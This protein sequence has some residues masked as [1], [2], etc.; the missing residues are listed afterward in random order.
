MANRDLRLIESVK[1]YIKVMVPKFLEETKIREDR[2]LQHPLDNDIVKMLEVFELREEDDDYRIFYYVKEIKEIWR[3]IIEKSIK[4]LRFFDG[5]EPFLDNVSKNPIA[6]GVNELSEYF[7]QYTQFETMLYGGGKYYRD[8]VVHVFRVW[9]LGLDCLLD[10]EGEYLKRINIQE[11][12]TVNSFEKICI[13]SM[14][15]LTH[16]LGYPLEKAQ[17]II[18]KT[19]T[20]MKSFVSNPTVLL[21]LSFDGIQN[22]MNDFVVRFMSSKMHQVEGK[23]PLEK[24]SDSVEKPFVARLQPKYYFK[25][26]K[27]LERYNHGILSAIIVYKLLIYFLESD[28]NINEDYR[29]DK[30]EARQFY[31]RREILRA[32][33]AHTCHDVYHLDML[34]F[35]FLL[36]MADDAQE[37][38]RKRISELYVKQ[39]SNY[40][41]DSI[42]PF[43]DVKKSTKG[44]DGDKQINI[45][46][47]IVKEQFKFPKGEEDN[48]KDILASLMRQREGY[49]ELFRDGQDT[50]KRN[51]IF[52]KICDVV[53]E[54]SKAVKFSIQFL[55]SNE[56][57]PTFKICV[58]SSN[59][60]AISETY[61]KNFLQKVYKG[62]CVKQMAT[63]EDK[64]EYEIMDK[65]EGIGN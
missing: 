27:S 42:T 15:A 36:I 20:M 30:E 32:I 48:L 38:G 60:N 6:Y 14:I 21:D 63:Y 51:F 23:C 34:N 58:S 11:G 12:V 33:A 31:I 46:K 16:D 65:V 59:K 7:G 37:W 62:Y 40:E 29:F 4:C 35:G 54:E 47:F 56:E 41:F 19:K 52:E 3:L 45:H 8:H 61:G 13:W 50:A 24:K 22:N 10:N 49:Q 55:I 26:Q 1:E 39:I 43:F 28:F 9:L 53:Y 18:E 64:I 25:F 2:V 5:R 17:E 44:V 57:K